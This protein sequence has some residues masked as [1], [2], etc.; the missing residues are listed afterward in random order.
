MRLLDSELTI[1]WYPGTPGDVADPLVLLST[2]DRVEEGSFPEVVASQT[3]QVTGYVRGGS[4]GNFSRGNN[5][6]SIS[7]ETVRSVADPMTAMETALTVAAGLPNLVGWIRIQL[8]RKSA[9]WQIPDVVLNEIGGRPVRR[10]GL[11]I[12]PWTIRGGKLAI[13]TGGDDPPTIYTPGE[14]LS[15]DSTPTDRNAILAE[16]AE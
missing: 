15:E 2:S 14:M 4:V 13:Y 3:D 5:S 12:H 11:L 7:F 8:A 6:T 1:T 10:R 16:D 9:Q